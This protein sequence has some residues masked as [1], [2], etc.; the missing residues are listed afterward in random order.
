MTTLGHI[1]VGAT[2][3]AISI[4]SRQRSWRL[5]LYFVFIIAI[6]NA[7]DWPLPGWGHHRLTFSHSL[8]VNAVAM[9]SAAMVFI[10]FAGRACVRYYRGFIA[11][12]IAAWFSHFLLD[13]L[14]VDSGLQML[15]PFS[16]AVVSLPIP[17]LRTMP[18]VPPPFDDAIWQIFLWELLTFAPLLM[19]AFV[20][21]KRLHAIITPSSPGPELR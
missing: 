9:A 4:P 18:H 8:L 3:G 16:D 10:R 20:L 12:C 14:Y 6:A 5:V 21:R 7:P 11:G 1:I 2:I 15:W 13:T 17:W 19:I